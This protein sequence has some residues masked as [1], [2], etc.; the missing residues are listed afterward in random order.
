MNAEY[1]LLIEQARALIESEPDPI[2]NAAN[3]ASLIYHN[4]SD[5]N[6]AG[7]Y[8]YRKDELVL[9]PFMGQV[10]CTRIP[11]GK[12]VCGTAFETKQTLVVADVHEFEG[13]IACDSASES[14]VVVPFSFNGQ[15]NIQDGVAGV[16][17]IDSPVKNRFGAAEQELFELLAHLYVQESEGSV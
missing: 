16:L 8:F 1:K 6:W 4:V 3:L 5:L 13:H 7:F 17:D 9:G 15:T 2:A 11:I 14:E 10:A 12:G